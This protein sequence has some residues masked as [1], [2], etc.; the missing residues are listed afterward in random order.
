MSSRRTRYTR[1]RRAGRG[2]N[3][4][5]QT[6]EVNTNNRYGDGIALEFEAGGSRVNC[7]L[8]PKGPMGC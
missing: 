4:M 2:R 8:R 5:S 7:N 6:W 1:E 3:G